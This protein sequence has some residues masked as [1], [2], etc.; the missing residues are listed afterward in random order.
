MSHVID[1]EEYKG[2][3]HH[4]VIQLLDLC[5]ENDREGIKQVIFELELDIQLEAISLESVRT[6]LSELDR[7]MS[8]T[9]RRLGGEG[10]SRLHIQSLVDCFKET[11]SLKE[12]ISQIEE[13]LYFCA[14]ELSSLNNKKSGSDI[15][16]IKKYIEKNYDES[17]TLKDIAAQFYIHPVYLGQLFKK[18]YGVY[19][20]DFL[21][22]VRIRKAKLILKHT[23]L[24]IYQV[25]DE[26]GFGS[27]DYFVTQFEKLE[28]VTP[29][30]YRKQ[31]IE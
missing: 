28:G 10:N 19:Y 31:L 15:Y 30:K 21:L 2:L 29:S 4:L 16:R 27:P 18:T 17:L 9:F 23:D 25:A 6:F 8:D 14:E 3:D 5:E 26:V 24:R 7:Q 12:L 22:A 20:K 1:Y 13:T 11:R